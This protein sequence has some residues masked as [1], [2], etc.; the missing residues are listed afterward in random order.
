MSKK[1]QLQIIRNRLVALLTASTMAVSLTG[2]TK[3]DVKENNQD[4]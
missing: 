3:K 2:C 4:K 1:E